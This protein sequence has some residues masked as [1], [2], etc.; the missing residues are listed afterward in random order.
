MRQPLVKI[1]G[2]QIISP[3]FLGYVIYPK[4]INIVWGND[5]RF[6]KLPKYEKEDAELIQVDWLEVT[7]WIDNVLEKKTY[8]VGRCH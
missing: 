2:T 5:K 8:D 7:G 3:H 6:W 1:E 4:A